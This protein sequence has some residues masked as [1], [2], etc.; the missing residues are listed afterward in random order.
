MAP[1]TP[2]TYHLADGHLK[3]IMKDPIDPLPT[4]VAAYFFN[5][6]K[7][8]RIVGANGK[9]VSDVNKTVASNHSQFLMSAQCW[10]FNSYGP[11]WLTKN[12]G[13]LALFGPGGIY[14][15]GKPNPVGI[16]HIDY[17][18][19]GQTSNGTPQVEV[20]A[21]G[22]LDYSYAVKAAA[23]VKAKGLQFIFGASTGCGLTGKL[24]GYP[25]K[26]STYLAQKR[27]ALVANIPGVDMLYIQSQQA[28]GTSVWSNFITQAVAQAHSVKPTM[29]VILGIAMNPHNPPTKVTTAMLIAAYDDAIKAGA[30]G[31]YHN[32]ELGVNA[33]QPA[34]VYTEF[35]KQLYA[36]P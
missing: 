26:Y 18:P 29:P 30:A 8:M 34:S 33:K 17:D 27:P 22:K 25:N 3:D 2:P 28:I 20:D 12:P 4:N 14:G 35:F 32:I 1:S 10:L 36:R 15:P 11:N 23:L 6:P 13:I 21:I 19:E 24:G 16:T 31:I 7:G 9:S 5:Q